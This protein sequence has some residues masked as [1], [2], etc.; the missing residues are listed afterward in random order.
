[1][2]ER[3]MLNLNRSEPWIISI[4][5]WNQGQQPDILPS[6]W[7]TMYL[8]DKCKYNNDLIYPSEKYPDVIDH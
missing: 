2:T 6:F 7:P 4:F 3:K 8:F 1:M 5:I